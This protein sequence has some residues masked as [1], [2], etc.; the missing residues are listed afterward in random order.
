MERLSTCWFRG[1][2]WLIRESD[3]P[4]DVRIK[5]ALTAPFVIITPLML[6]VI[7]TWGEVHDLSLTFLIGNGLHISAFLLFFVCGITGMN[8]RIT[9]DFVLFF[10]F[11][12]III[13]DIYN[14]AELRPRSWSQT[15]VVFD[16]CLVLDR[17]SAI[18]PMVVLT[19]MWLLV[20]STE[21]AFR[22]GLHDQVSSGVPAVCDCPNP[23]CPTAVAGAYTTGISSVLVVLVD[24][25]LTRGFATDLRVQLRK[26]KAS[27]EL[28]AKVTA[29]L[30]RFDVDVAESA[31][32]R[33][34]DLPPEMT[35][36]FR[37]LLCHL[38]D[39]RS[40]L[41]ISVLA[42]KDTECVNTEHMMV[43]EPQFYRLYEL[44]VSLL[45]YSDKGPLGEMIRQ[46]SFPQSGDA[47]RLFERARSLADKAE[48]LRYLG[49]VELLVLDIYTKEGVDLDRMMGFD[50]VPWKQFERYG[51]EDELKEALSLWEQ[52]GGYTGVVVPPAGEH[53]EGVE[54]L[55]RMLNE[56][57]L[58]E[59]KQ[60]Y[61]SSK[62]RMEPQN[63]NL[64][65]SL[66]WALRTMQNAEGQMA[67]FV[68][69]LRELLDQGL[70]NH[71]G[72]L[73]CC[74]I[75][76]GQVKKAGHAFS[77]RA[78][79]SG[80]FVSLCGGEELCCWRGLSGL[81]PERV[82]GHRK[83]RPGQFVGWVA[84]TGVSLDPRVAREFAKDRETSVLFQLRGVSEFIPLQEVSQYPDEKDLL[85][86]PFS[87]W[88][89]EGVVEDGKG[90]VVV[91]LRWRGHAGGQGELEA[92]MRKR[93]TR[94]NDEIARWVKG[95]GAAKRKK[96]AVDELTRDSRLTVSCASKLLSTPCTGA[97]S[98]LDSPPGV[99]EDWGSIF[100]S[101]SS[102]GSGPRRRPSLPLPT[103]S[104]DKS[105]L[106]MSGRF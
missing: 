4:E 78:R 47:F 14:L 89:V 29:A 104:T 67:E 30:G 26:V 16:L 1:S 48:V 35:I 27:V 37:Q 23:P 84:P 43:E 91:V 99:V 96:A 101:G 40:S 5:R 72:V 81:P 21:T 59:I 102:P 45:Q 87:T 97:S 49:A 64:G 28:A 17:T 68:T 39:Y 54:R 92:I 22:F 105:A 19:T 73:C 34:T 38:K 31:L 100:D 42:E 24:L 103:Q 53:S 88:E 15:V 11:A 79:A 55:V 57:A 65:N 56:G 50:S 9:M 75:S 90:P 12:G 8:M 80:L 7:Y 46:L 6:Y 69:A 60:V 32:E 62:K 86:A 70:L 83:L 95:N 106:S 63:P 13:I 18:T 2:G 33:G 36:S 66:S 98:Q 76:L 93:I 10:L 74:R 41:P 52:R 44:F 82:Q 51:T 77:Y 3:S 85:I 71:I 20:A 58:E 94:D 25:Y 61:Q